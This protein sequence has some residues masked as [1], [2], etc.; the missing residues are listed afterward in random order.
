MLA[1]A[2]AFPGRRFQRKEKHCSAVKSTSGRRLPSCSS[3]FVHPCRVS[4]CL[5][6]VVDCVTLT[7]TVLVGRKQWHLLVILSW[8][9]QEWWPSLQLVLYYRLA[10]VRTRCLWCFF[11]L[12]SGH[13]RAWEGRS[14]EHQNGTYITGVCSHMP[15]QQNNFYILFSLKKK[16]LIFIKKIPCS[17]KEAGG[18]L[19]TSKTKTVFCNCCSRLQD[20]AHAHAHCMFCLSVWVCARAFVASF[21]Y[22]FKSSITCFSCDEKISDRKC[23]V[24]NNLRNVKVLFSLSMWLFFVQHL[25]RCLMSLP[26]K[27]KNSV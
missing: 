13:V 25:F 23:W 17:F 9:H 3:V 20:D 18:F 5:E 2:L 16:L 10:A 24:Q 19:N 8:Q 7:A 4:V 22:L 26:R 11:T 27:M 1:L 14:T 21:L 6:I 12:P 15:Y